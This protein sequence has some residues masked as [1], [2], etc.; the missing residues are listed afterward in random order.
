MIGSA[1]A[2]LLRNLARSRGHPITAVQF[3]FFVIG[4]CNRT[5]SLRARQ[6]SAVNWVLLILVSPLLAT[7]IEYVL[8]TSEKE[9]VHV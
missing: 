7:R 8:I 2:Y 5:V 3:E 6:L 4:S 9:D 1:R